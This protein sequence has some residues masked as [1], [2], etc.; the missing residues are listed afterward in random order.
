MRTSDLLVIEWAF[1]EDVSLKHF[2]EVGSGCG[3]ST[4]YF[5]QFCR[6]RGGYLHAFDRHRP[7]AK[8]QA[9]WPLLATFHPANVLT[10]EL[11]EL[12]AI[13]RRSHAFVLLDNGNKPRELELYAKHVPQGSVLAVHDFQSEVERQC[14][15][16]SIVKD[17]GLTEYLTDECKE[18]HSSLRCWRRE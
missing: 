17:A 11:P 6:M 2:V 8:Y 14:D 10:E 1:H 5:A 3:L 9:L 13:I 4:L 7:S 15:W 12:V 18:W 16:Q